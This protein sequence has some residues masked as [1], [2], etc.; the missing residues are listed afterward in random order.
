MIYLKCRAVQQFWIFYIWIIIF[1]DANRV[2]SLIANEG[3]HVNVGTTSVACKLCRYYVNM[4]MRPQESK[5]MEFIREY[6]KR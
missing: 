2:E 5:K 1:Q 6:R 4:L 3:I